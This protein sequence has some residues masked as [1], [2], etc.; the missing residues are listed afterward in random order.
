MKIVLAVFF[1]IAFTSGTGL[2]IT[3]DEAIKRAVDGSYL[4][5]EQKEVVNS[6]RFSYISTIDPYLPR[7]D[8]QSSYIRSLNSST[9]VS[10]Y[11]NFSSASNAGSS[12]DAYTFAGSVSYR[13]FDGGERYAK[14]KGSYSLLERE[15]ERYK[16][17]HQD[18]LFNIKSAFYTALGSRLVVEK[19][20]EAFS[21]AERIYNL[22]VAR[23]REGITKKSDVLQAEVRM[24][25]SKID[26]QR[27]EREYEKALEDL[28]SLI[29]M[30]VG[31]R[32][33][34][35]G[36]LEAP[37]YSPHYESLVER[38]LRLKPEIITQEKEIER[39]NMAY[40]EKRSA[41]FPRIDAE[42]Q[43]TRQDR[44]FFPEGRSD[45]FMI[46]FSFPLFDGVGRHYNMQ[47]AL[48]NVNAA[49]QRL[50]E[51]KRTVGLDIIKAIKDYEL[52]LANVSLYKELVR[53]ATTTFNQ[54]LGEYRVGKGDILSLLQSEKDLATAKE[55]E[56]EALYRANVALSY[57]QKVAY[58]YDE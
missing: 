53:E 17:I 38:A 48:S 26:V 40:V 39:L 14:R 15:K 58:I 16:G 21:T 36:P 52:T 42:L 55:N 34:A 25:T 11:S 30:K 9:S 24:T 37:A 54:L 35:E 45:S 19:R 10:S 6:Y 43:Q 50:E 20:Q 47:G 41:W 44:R 23:Y 46:N 2:S 51:T 27:A 56:V 8:I 31:E 18:V 1:I 57:L 29:F 32:T 4:L 3:L 7:V 13:I 5:K 28:K 12:L 22:T 49:K 33:D